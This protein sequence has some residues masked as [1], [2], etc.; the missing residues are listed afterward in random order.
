MFYFQNAASKERSSRI[1]ELGAIPADEKLK[2]TY[3]FHYRGTSFGLIKTGKT[4]IEA[5]LQIVNMTTVDKRGYP[6]NFNVGL[7]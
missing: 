5:D 4:T 1:T 6:A 3:T 2:E 7:H